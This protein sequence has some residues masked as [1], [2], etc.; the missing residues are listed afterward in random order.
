MCGGGTRGGG[1][2]VAR[3][4]GIMA[5]RVSGRGV[6]GCRGPYGGHGDGGTRGTRSPSCRG[7]GSRSGGTAHIV[8]GKGRGWYTGAVG[9]CRGHPAVPVDIVMVGTRIANAVCYAGI[10]VVGRY[11]PDQ[12]GGAYI[13]PKAQVLSSIVH[14]SCTVEPY[15][16]QVQGHID[17][18]AG[19]G[20]VAIDPEFIVGGVHSFHP[21]F[22]EEDVGLN[23]IVISAVNHDFALRIQIIDRA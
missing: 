20:I 23:L 14:A 4:A 6:C 9:V 19:I 22:V 7:H 21:N 5:A 18:V 15:T 1:S 16:L 12:R 17:F 2:L 13:N 10:R 11:V 3:R 8:V